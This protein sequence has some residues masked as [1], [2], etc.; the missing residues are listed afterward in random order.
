M[1][2]SNLLWFYL[3]SGNSKC[4]VWRWGAERRGARLQVHDL[5]ARALQAGRGQVAEHVRRGAGRRLG[6]GRIVAS[7][8]EAPN[9]LV[10]LEQSG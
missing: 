3:D 1:K 6:F 10:N 9:I 5:C 7:E 2:I 8:K 4:V